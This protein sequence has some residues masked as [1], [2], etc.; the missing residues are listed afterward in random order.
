MNILPSAGA[1]GNMS[2]IPALFAEYGSVNASN[3]PVDVSGRNKAFSYTDS[4]SN[5]ITGSSPMLF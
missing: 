1:W 2:T 5:V 3:Y 4:N